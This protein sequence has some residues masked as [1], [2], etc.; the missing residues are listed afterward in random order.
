MRR[1]MEEGGFYVEQ[2]AVKDIDTK[3]NV[4]AGGVLVQVGRR[5]HYRLIKRT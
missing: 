2:K 5:R 1:L 3:A 4:P